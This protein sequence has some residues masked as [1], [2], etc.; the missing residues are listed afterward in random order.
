MYFYRHRHFD[1]TVGR[2]LDRDP[3][4]YWA[5]V[6]TCTVTSQTVQSYARTRPVLFQFSYL[7]PHRLLQPQTPPLRLL[8]WS[9]PLRSLAR[10]P[11][12]SA[13]AIGSGRTQRGHLPVGLPTGGMIIRGQRTAEQ[14]T[15]RRR[16]RSGVGELSEDAEDCHSTRHSTLPPLWHD[17]PR[18]DRVAR[19]HVLKARLPDAHTRP[20]HVAQT[21]TSAGRQA[22]PRAGSSP[23]ACHA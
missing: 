14:A 16:R 23:R 19:Q 9:P 15:I 21:Q 13:W 2:W 20:P 3:I 12:A 1:P 5:G 10:L 8:L 18:L 7:P 11:Q 22:G 6:L 4:G 17:Q